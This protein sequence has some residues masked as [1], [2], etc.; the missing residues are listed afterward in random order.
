MRI[1]PRITTRF[2]V[3]AMMLSTLT[4]YAVRAQSAGPPANRTGQSI[5]QAP[6]SAHSTPDQE[7]WLKELMGLTRTKHGVSQY[8]RNH[9][10]V[11]RAFIPVV[12][13]PSKSTVIVLCNNK[14]VAL[15]TIVRND[16]FIV[17]KASQLDGPATCQLNDGTRY[18]ARL[19]NKDDKTDLAMLKISAEY[20]P[21]IQWQSSGSPLRGSWVVTPGVDSL[22]ITAGIVSLLPHRVRGGK[23]GVQLGES[24]QGP[25]V[26]FVL[27]GSGAEKAGVKPGDVITAVNG[28]FVE[29]VDSLINAITTYAPGDRVHLAV[30]RNN[31]KIQLPV[32]L[33]NR[34]GRLGSSHASFQQ[35][36]G[37]PL[38]HRRVG[39]AAV[40]EHDSVLK[41]EQCGG[42]LVDLNGR[43]LGINIARAS[44]VASFA[45]P[46]DEVLTLLP[47]LMVDPTTPVSHARQESTLLKVPFPPA[48]LPETS[49]R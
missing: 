22:P 8:S 20:L 30:L 25:R 14:Q 40:L 26:H 48:N 36:L 28:R 9:A 17:T 49:R 24:E 45:I 21:T 43:A 15:G 46:T 47:A 16:G 29:T 27:P 31:Q 32:P 38:S 4:L 23:I 18:E 5:R 37:G 34:S 41:P 1:Q 7:S 33:G 13:E 6:Q 10:S 35:R 11:L 44:R 39:F 42:P 12:S 19:L 3:M 2:L